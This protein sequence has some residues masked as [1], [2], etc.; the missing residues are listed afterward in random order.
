MCNN[1]E[2]KR[3]QEKKTNIVVDNIA[4]EFSNKHIK[5]RQKLFYE[6]LIVYSR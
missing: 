4:R 3:K 1:K 2:G 6:K 5:L